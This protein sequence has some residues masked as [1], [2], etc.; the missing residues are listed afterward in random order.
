MPSP[1]AIYGSAFRICARLNLPRL[2][3]ALAVPTLR[4]LT[5]A[6]RP[7]APVVLILPK[8]GFTE[9]IMSALAPAK[10]VSV[11]A[12]PRA[13]VHEIAA[14][15]LPYFIDDN[16]Y[17]SCGAS[18]DGV[19]ADY[20]R[21]LRRMLRALRRMVR[22]DAIITGN[23][24]YAPDR[25][26]ASASR[27][28]GIP[29]IALHKENLKTPGRVAFFERIYQ[30]RRGAFT[31]HRILVYNAIEK[32]LQVRAGVA[33]SAR[34]D[35]VGM[36]RLD[37]MH[38]W[39]RSHAGD[40]AVNRILFFL[41][42]PMTGMPRIARKT[43]I[44]GVVASEQSE[45]GINDISV[46]VLCRKSCRAMLTVARSNPDI[47]VIVKSK[48]RSRDL[49]ELC[50]LF[51][52]DREADFP[53]NVRIAH[54]GDVLSLLGEASVVCGFNST[55]LLEA[56]AAGKPVVLPW[57]A[58]ADDPAVQP[59]VIDLRDVATVAGSVDALQAHLVALA[60][61]PRPVPSDLT[62]SERQC[63]TVWTGNADGGAA[64]RAHKAIMDALGVAESAVV[65]KSGEFRK[66]M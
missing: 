23:F 13:V 38:A 8:D 42:L 60:R 28:L 21:F 17:A 16:N 58:E 54:G 33:E 36:P 43:G 46:A 62:P 31:G 1:R 15:F 63:L 34:I 24:G 66:C 47:E 40:V 32:D 51:G 25:E 52:L 64:A 3:A 48:G 30:E 6:E 39:R 12:L 37:R 53:P 20:R 26:L 10:D 59:F 65:P 19:K 50:E 9:D 22:H 49:A 5:R 18:F 27:D 35:I 55:A 29:F 57:F 14:A 2:A 4:R 61:S 7:D 45:A 11:L 56:I 44:R 41:F